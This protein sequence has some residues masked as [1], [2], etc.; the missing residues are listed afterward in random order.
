MTKVVLD[1]NVVVSALLFDGKPEQIL[2]TASR[3][4]IRII[5]TP[6]ISEEIYCVLTT[7]FKQPEYVAKKLL[8]S[9]TS[10]SKIVVPKLKVRLI[11]YLPDNKILEA[12]LAGKV[13]YVITGDRKHLLPLKAFKDIPI[14]TPDQFLRE[15]ETK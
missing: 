5:L 8:R 13:D 15:I 6:A 7:K 1:S 12:G 2:F 3:G 9:V 14:V 10:I 11:K 4:D